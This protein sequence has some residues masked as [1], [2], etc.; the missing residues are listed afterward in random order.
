MPGHLTAESMAGLRLT[1][2]MVR[3]YLTRVETIVSSKGQIV[4]PSPLRKRD[5]IR[6][7][8]RFIVQRLRSGDYRLIRQQAPGDDL[9]AWLRACPEKDY[10]TAPRFADTTADI[11]K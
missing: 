6:T 10:F 11:L 1:V 9:V 8:Q 4:L 3:R 5:N 7:G 2:T